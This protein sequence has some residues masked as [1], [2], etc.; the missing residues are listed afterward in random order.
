MR[1]R[2]LA[3]LHLPPP[4]YGVT[5]FNQNIIKALSGKFSIT[6][7]PINTAKTLE[8]IDKI[9][10]TKIF[11]SLKIAF[12]TFGAL[13]KNKYDVCYMSLSPT[14]A[15]FFKDLIIVFL[16][17]LSGTKIMYHMH[18]G[19]IAQRKGL[20]ERISYRFCFNNAK[21]IILSEPLYDDLKQY[22]HRD[23][24]YILPNAIPTVLDDK[25]FSKIAE[26]RQ[27]QEKNITLLFLSNLV[28]SKG[29]MEALSAASMLKNSGY[30][31]QFIFTGRCFDISKDEF[32][33]RVKEL[34]IE[35]YVSY[36][37]FVTGEA[38]HEL[39]KNADIFIYPTYKD[40]FPLVLL[41]AMQYGLPIVSTDTGAIPDLIQNEVNGFI[42][43]QHD[44]HALTQKIRLLMESAELRGE[45]GKAGRERFI[46]NYSFE[47]FEQKLANILCAE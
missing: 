25:E 5:I 42:C 24:A 46:K 1:K 35:N 15:A 36:H 21:I 41:E 12:K 2:I 8:T 26:H 28:R 10:V 17:K 11:L 16:V 4:E 40:M 9:N 30:E 32:Q 47:K 37:G 13:L 3:L 22:V 27:R 14:G 44:T 45:M 19:G 6:A 23:N 39:L 34:G 38:K 18:G 7:I 20:L 31:F 43:P 33:A 29:V